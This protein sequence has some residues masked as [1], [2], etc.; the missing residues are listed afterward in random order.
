VTT[1]DHPVAEREVMITAALGTMLAPL[2]ST[3][4]VVALPE[5]LDDFGRSLA[6]GSWIVLSYLV[7]MAAV[8]PL[9]GSLGDRYGRRRLFLVGLSG[10]LV[11]TVVAAL[12][13]RI[14]VLLAARTVQA[15]TGAVAIPNGTALVRTLVPIQRQGRAFGTIGSGIAFAAAAGPPLGGLITDGLGW[16]WIFLANILL[17]APAFALASRL[18][19]DRPAGVPARFDLAGA[20]LMTSALVTLALALTSW[21]LKG[22]PLWAGPLLALLGVTAAELLRRHVRAHPRPV[23]SLG[24]FRRPGFAA[25]TA[26]VL[27][28]NMAMYT[29]LLALPV[30]L[31]RRLDW[32]SSRVGLLL[33]GLSM[34]MV[35]FSPVGGWLADR[36]GK[37]VPAT[38]GTALIALGTVP[39]I[40]L[41]TGWTWWMLLIP[42]VV[43]GVG[44]GLSAAPVQATAIQAVPSSEAGQAAG[45]FSTMRYL[46]S[47]LGSAGMAAILAG[48]PPAISAFRVLFALLLVASLGALLSASRLE[49]RGALAAAPAAASAR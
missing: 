43:V 15:I 13:W 48:D 40:A 35:V 38:L 10:F 5:I 27:L 25:A 23:V 4:I 12:A 11:A 28:S 49:P 1:A 47:I 44:I 31:T 17:I 18:P 24:V 22:I 32:G 21:R 9:G 29:T 7:A 45:M 20:A 42:L 26:T 16:R 6:W 8:Q 30:F 37:R 33:A 14:E 39:L 41:G 3:M 19:R 46:G 2:N 36:R 34:Q